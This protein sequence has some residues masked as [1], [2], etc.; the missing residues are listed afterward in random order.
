[1]WAACMHASAEAGCPCKVA[2]GGSKAH[3]QRHLRRDRERGV[4]LWVVARRLPA[5]RDG[6]L[7]VRYLPELVLARW[8]GR[9]GQAQ[10]S[11]NAVDRFNNKLV[12]QRQRAAACVAASPSDPDQRK[13]GVSLDRAGALRRTLACPM[14]FLAPASSLSAAARSPDYT[15]ARHRPRNGSAP[16]Q[17]SRQL[18][19]TPRGPREHA[20]CRDA[21]RAWLR[22]GGKREATSWS[23]SPCSMDLRASV[24]SSSPAPGPQC[25]P[26]HASPG[27]LSSPA[28]HPQ[29]T[30]P[31]STSAARRP[32][33]RHPHQAQGGR[34]PSE[35]SV[36]LCFS[37]STRSSSSRSM[38]WR[39]AAA[40]V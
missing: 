28:T 6:R 29:Q 20:S 3:L 11:Q 22:T 18:P 34:R 13:R 8:V 36:A 5:P 16:L 24:A 14:Y 38:P 31:R 4:L 15:T 30:A 25:L 21:P 17:T 1:V 35:R 12:N 33:A 27:P 32:R 2:Q 9:S 23:I 26:R 7:L 39:P 37:A 10:I 40:R 19:G